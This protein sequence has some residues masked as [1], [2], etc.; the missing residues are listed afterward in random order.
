MP[1]SSS[2]KEILYIVTSHD[3]S[4]IAMAIGI[5]LI[6]KQ[7]KFTNLVV[8]KKHFDGLYKLETNLEFQYEDACMI[9]NFDKINNKEL[10][11]FTPFEL[12][13]L[14]Y[15]DPNAKRKTK[16]RFKNH[17]NDK[18]HFGIFD[19]DQRKFIITS[20]EDALYVDMEQ[21]QE[22]DLDEKE[23]ISMIQNIVADRQTFYVLANRR[24]GKL[25]FYIF[26]I[27]MSDPNKPVDYLL[28]W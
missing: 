8:Y 3:E 25:G 9:F 18:P 14:H 26:T 12:F 11:F 10:L 6:K 21:Q 2:D 5:K 24:K 23:K 16:Y 17:L 1:T 15:N 22:I 28:N 13:S 19:L 20:D 27:D 4:K 7:I